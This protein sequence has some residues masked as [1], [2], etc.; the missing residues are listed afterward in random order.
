MGQRARQ[1][2]CM[3]RELPPELGNA[4]TV[5]RARGLGVSSGRLQAKR[6]AKPFHGAR[7][8]RSLS[9]LERLALLFAVLPTHA[10]ACG[11]TAA[12]LHGM[13]LPLALEWQAIEHPTIGVALPSN[14]VRRAGVAGRALKVGPD[15]LCEKTG[16][17]AT[18]P[19]RTWVDLATSVSLPRF[20]AVT[21]HL[22]SR[23]RPV[24]SLE[25]LEQAHSRAG[26]GSGARARA[27]ALSLCSPGSES[28]RES[29]L[30]TIL[31]L[32]GLP[33]P[34]TNVEIYHR[35]RFI[36]RV[37]MLYRAERV[38]VEYDGEHHVTPGRWSRDQMRRAELES[39]GY[40]VTVVTAR[41]FDDPS[42]VIARI[43]RHLAD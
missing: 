21:D 1:S 16:L 14:R 36:A 29:E 28:P 10:F 11:P 38:V 27:Q 43:R 41:D 37:D 20:V 35:G 30:R 25:R 42:V 19:A 31:V 15:D 26:R 7:A 40:R 13:P 3:S 24:I 34:E 12:F 4:F 39:L 8:Q 22:I 5:R 23:R 33:M 32:A 9:E 6:L 18:S 2:D 17:P